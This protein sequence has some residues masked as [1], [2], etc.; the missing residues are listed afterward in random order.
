MD[1]SLAVGVAPKDYIVAITAVLGLPAELIHWTNPKTVGKYEP[2]T[3][4]NI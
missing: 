4:P 3:H 1:V 2:F